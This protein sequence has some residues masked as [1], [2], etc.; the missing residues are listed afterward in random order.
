V[1]ILI[2]MLAAIGLWAG[3]ACADEARDDVYAPMAVFDDLAGRA[4]R[5]KG[6]GPNGQPIVDVSRFEFIMGGRALQSTHKLED[7]DYGGRTIFFFDEGAKEYV[8]HYFTT[9]GFHTTGV[10]TPTENGFTAVETVRGLPEIAEVRSTWVIDGAGVTVTT[11]HI[12]HDGE[13]SPGDTIVYVE[14]DDPGAL[15][16]S[17]AK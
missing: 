4:F 15:Y 1:R 11:S 10:V 13:E 14:I 17:N 9:V 6:T 7:S 16:E 12:N 5:G 3:A 8:F 2:A